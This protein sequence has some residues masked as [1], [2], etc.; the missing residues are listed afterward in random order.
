M[1]VLLCV[2]AVLKEYLRW[3]TVPNRRE[4]LTYKMVDKLY[5]DVL[6]SMVNQP[7]YTPDNLRRGGQSTYD[8]V[9]I[10]VMPKLEIS[11][12]TRRIRY[13]YIVTFYIHIMST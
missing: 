4:P 9:F 13:N 11:M 7:T 1:V 8:S 3:E 10:R 12:L 5:N 2:Q 6:S